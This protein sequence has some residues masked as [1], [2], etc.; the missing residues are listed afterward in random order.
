MLLPSSFAF[1][2]I[3]TFLVLL[4]NK[5][6]NPQRSSMLA[7]CTTASVVCY[8]TAVSKGSKEANVA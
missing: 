1:A 4:V 5:N 8:T 2:N 7:C 6:K 3:L